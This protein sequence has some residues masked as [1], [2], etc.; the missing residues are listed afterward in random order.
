MASTEYGFT[1]AQWHSAIAEATAILIEAARSPQGYITYS[2]LAGRLRSIAIGYHDPAMDYLLVQVSTEE[3]A[4]GRGL[5]SVV[6]VH[7]GGDLEPGKGFY[8]LA[9]ELGFD[10]SDRLAFW[11]SEFRSVTEYWRNHR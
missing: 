7:K 1:D 6:V 9:E 10:V 2:D 8:E 3:H 5:L 11:S 4:A